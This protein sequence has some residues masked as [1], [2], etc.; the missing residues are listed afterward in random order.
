MK[1]CVERL[2]TQDMIR[3]FPDGSFRP[4]GTV[5]RAEFAAMVVKAFPQQPVIRQGGTFADVPANHWAK[6]AI[7]QAYRQG[8][9][10]GYANNLFNPNQPIPRTQAVVSLASGLKLTPT[11]PVEQVLTAF[12]DGASIPT[13]GKS[14][15]AA[16]TQKQLVVNYPNIR[17]FNPN[18][19]ATRGEIAAFLCQATQNIG[20]IPAQYVA[21]VPNQSPISRS[22]LRGVWLTNIDSQVLFD[23]NT[24]TQAIDR[25]QQLNFNTLYP[26]VW[27]GG[28]TLYPS[29]VAQQTIGK[30]LDP[31]P[32]LQGRDMLK[33]IVDQGHAKKMAVI[34][35]FE[36]GFMAPADSELAKRH[37]DWLLKRRDGSTVWMEGTLPRVWLNP[38]HPQVQ[39]FIT[40][41]VVELVKNYDIDGIQF[42]DH[43]GFPVDF[44]YDDLTRQLQSTPYPT[45]IE[46]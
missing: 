44:G 14:A 39:K 11:A 22:E 7:A 42:D 19:S 26:T 1:P 30:S 36:F 6:N 24:L 35:W 43:F 38:Y 40:D 27:N 25:L 41:L 46:S 9:V 8:F 37:P 4:N 21:Q 45:E 33:E 15:I 17:R 34:P 18:Q 5:T 32:G 28:Y 31:T 16:A 12:E 13:Y 10:S 23:R 2:A 20:L 29:S 3:G